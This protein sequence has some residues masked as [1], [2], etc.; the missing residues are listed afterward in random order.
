[1]AYP[2]FYIRA[3][4][5]RKRVSDLP[6]LLLEIKWIQ[7]P[8]KSQWMYSL[9]EESSWLSREKTGMGVNDE[10]VAMK[11]EEGALSSSRS[12]RCARPECI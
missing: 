9:R 1:M 2:G 7:L 8:L 11:E 3:G 10:G 6:L 12:W 4:V 5:H